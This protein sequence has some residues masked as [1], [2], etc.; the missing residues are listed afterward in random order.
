MYFSVILTRPHVTRPRPR[1]EFTRLE[2]RQL[3]LYVSATLSKSQRYNIMLV[4]LA[5][6]NLRRLILKKVK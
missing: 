1:P 4:R 5:T 3:I 2:V 6:N